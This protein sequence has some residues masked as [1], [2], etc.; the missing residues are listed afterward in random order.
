M[1]AVTVLPQQFA[2]YREKG[3][4]RRM[5]TTPVKPS[6]MLGAQLLMCTFLAIMTVITLLTLAL[7]A[8]E[9][10]LPQNLAAYLVSYLLAAVS[11]FAMGMLV[12][13]LAPNNKGA[14]AIG[15]VL[16][17][18]LLFFAGLWVPRDTMNDT[19]RTISDLTPLGSGVQALHD[20]TAGQWPTLLAVVVMLGWTIAAGG[21]AARYFR[22]E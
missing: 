9:V 10:D 19:L 1:M 8:F 18:P 3:I 20:A 15:T 5:R 22:W 4:L 13:S 12:A 17:G 7:V 16:L 6:A 21:L 11:M 2:I 14:T